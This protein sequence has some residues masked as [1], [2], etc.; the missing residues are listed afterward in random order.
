M[1]PLALQLQ[2]VGKSP[3]VGAGNQTGVLWKRST[4]SILPS[5]LTGP[6]PSTSKPPASAF[7]TGVRPTSILG[8]AGSKLRACGSLNVTG[9]H[10]LI[11]RGAV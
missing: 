5:H 3:Q 10:K 1:N 8:D 9:S 6:R 11:G 2:A 7:A 4:R